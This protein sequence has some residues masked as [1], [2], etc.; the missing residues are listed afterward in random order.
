[1]AKK[2]EIFVER[3]FYWREITAGSINFFSRNKN[4]KI[5]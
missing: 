1:M 4:I 3:L 5:D 2:D